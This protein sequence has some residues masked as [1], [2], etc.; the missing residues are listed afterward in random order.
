MIPAVSAMAGVPSGNLPDPRR[1]RRP[2]GAWYASA[3]SRL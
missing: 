2:P 3:P 1:R